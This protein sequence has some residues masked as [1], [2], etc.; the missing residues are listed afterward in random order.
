[1]F[2]PLEYVSL[3]TILGEELQIFTYAPN[4]CPLNS[5][6]SLSCHTPCGTGYPFKIII[7]EYSWHLD[8]LPSVW[9]WSCHYLLSLQ[10]SPPYPPSSNANREMNVYN[11]NGGF[12]SN[13]HII[14][15]ICLLCEMNY[16]PRAMG[17]QASGSCV[18][19]AY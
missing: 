10:P 16:D 9:H 5:E 19:Y 14:Y 4:S 18:Y 12:F 15:K 2:F 13:H 3:I 17:C 11:Y 8:L 1:M 6:A 7:T